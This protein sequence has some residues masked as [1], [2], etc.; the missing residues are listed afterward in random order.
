MQKRS[1]SSLVKMVVVIVLFSL[2][3][4]G[5]FYNLLKR[6]GFAESV[7]QLSG[8]TVGLLA[9]VAIEGFTRLR[10]KRLNRA[11]TKRYLTF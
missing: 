1:R 3:T 9:V 6:L 2:F 11:Q 7:A 5:F 10:I 8:M 4:W